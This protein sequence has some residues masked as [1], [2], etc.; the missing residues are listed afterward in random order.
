MASRK[1]TIV[2]TLCSTK[3]NQSILC[4]VNVFTNMKLL[5]WKKGIFNVYVYVFVV[6]V[7][8]AI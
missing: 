8:H 4:S 2:S 5:V 3:C 7:L 6:C 1:L